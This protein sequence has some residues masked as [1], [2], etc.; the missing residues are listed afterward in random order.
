MEATR[1][2][3]ESFLCL[4]QEM[5]YL[6][7]YPARLAFFCRKPAEQGGETIIGDMRE[8]TRRLPAN[9][10]KQL[11]TYGVRAVRNYGPAGSG[12]KVVSD[13]RDGIAW[14]DGFGT[15]DKEEVEILCAERGLQP[16]WQENGGLAVVAQLNPFSKHPVTGERFYR[17][18]IHTSYIDTVTGKLT[19]MMQGPLATG[20]TYGDGTP[21]PLEDA[22]HLHDLLNDVTECWPWQAGDTMIVDNLQV[23]HGRNRYSGTRETLVALLN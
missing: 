8:F 23:A 16:I 9:V 4:H 6:P 15:A 3:A 7:Q 22:Q 5:A 17:S 19:H 13:A 14:D 21:M 11:E 12:T 10:R 2:A 18:I 20:Y 1:V